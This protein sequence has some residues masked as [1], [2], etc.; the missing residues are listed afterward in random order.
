MKKILVFVQSNEHG[1]N[2]KKIARLYINKFTICA[3]DEFDIEVYCMDCPNE[4]SIRS[5]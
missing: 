1:N 4:N 5:G 2:L 3:S